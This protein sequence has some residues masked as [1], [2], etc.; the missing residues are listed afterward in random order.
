[1]WLGGFNFPRYHGGLMYWA[2][3]IGVAEVYRQIQQWHQRYGG[4]WA[5]A[6]LLRQVAETGTS[7]REVNPSRR[8]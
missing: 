3:G 7:F 1:M 4:R 5:R 6:A 8:M 2:D